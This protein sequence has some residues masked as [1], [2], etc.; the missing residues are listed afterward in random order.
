LDIVEAMFTVKE[1]ML[2]PA[3]TVDVVA[4]A[5][6]VAAGALDVAAGAEEVAGGA[7]VVEEDDEHP[8]AVRAAATATPTKP[9]L[10]KDLNVRWHCERERHPPCP[11]LPRTIPYPFRCTAVGYADSGHRRTRAPFGMKGRS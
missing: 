9:A 10:G 4:G 2:S 6:V 11:L 1:L 7:V 8:A 5:L 3:G